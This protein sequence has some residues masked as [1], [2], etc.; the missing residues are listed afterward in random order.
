[1]RRF[2]IFFCC[3]AVAL[4]GGTVMTEAQQFR[5]GKGGGGG[6]FGMFGGGGFGNDP[7]ALLRR[8]DV[9]K[10]LDL[11][12]EQTEKLPA[13]VLKAVGEVLNDKQMKRFRQIQLQSP[14]YQLQA[15]LKDEQLRKDLKINDS[16]TKS[17]EEVLEDQK[18]ELAELFKEAKGAGGFKGLGEKMQGITKETKEKVMG[19]LTSDQKKQYKQIIGDEFK[20]EQGGKK[21]ANNETN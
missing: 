6:G 9:K 5:Q 12:E 18:K 10:E 1:M 16:Q 20:F 3:G 8:G 13:A 14:G 2:G 11:S 17:I 21:K 15:F 7:L 19:V 4:L